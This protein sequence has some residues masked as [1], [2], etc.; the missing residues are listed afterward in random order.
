MENRHD[1]ESKS[2]C[3]NHQTF[4][5]KN[6][7][8]NAEHRLNTGSKSIKNGTKKTTVEGI[9]TDDLWRVT[10]KS[11]TI[12]RD[13]A[14]YTF[15]PHHKSKEGSVEESYMKAPHNHD[16]WSESRKQKGSSQWKHLLE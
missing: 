3:F 15:C 14:K 11:D 7:L 5:N 12:T 9:K 8:K 4:K 1:Q 10:N 6:H 13:G 2:C 16:E